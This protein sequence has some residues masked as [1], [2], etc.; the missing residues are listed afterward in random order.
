[1]KYLIILTTFFSFQILAADHL[2]LIGAGGEP[3]KESTIFDA[4][5]QN[6]AKYTAH[7][8]SVKVNVALN[9]GHQDTEK[10][11]K[12]S[13]SNAESKSNFFASDYQRLIQSYKRKLENNEIVAGDQ[14]LIYVESHGAAKQSRFKTHA[15]ATAEGTATDLNNLSG[16]T[17]VD[18]DQLEVIKNLAKRKGVKL[19]IVDTSCHSGNTL[20]LAD[21]NTCVIASTGPNHYGYTQFSRNFSS[22]MAKGKNLE[23]I[24]L[25]ARRNDATAGLPMIS[26]QTGQGITDL[27]YK[28]ITPYL[29]HFDSRHDK[30]TPYIEQ[31][32]CIE[33]YQS[34]I[35]T[36]NQIEALTIKK[37]K[38]KKLKRL[39]SDYEKSFEYIQT[40]MKKLGADRLKKQEHFKNDSHSISYTWKELL[41]TDFPR[42]TADL[43]TRQNQETSP[44]NQKLYQDLI[45]IYSSAETKKRDLL[46]THSD[47]LMVADQEKKIKSSIESNYFTTAAIATEERKLYSALYQKDDK[48]NPCKDFKL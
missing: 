15:I 14:L 8:P 20:A 35:A 38:L 2:M 36:F 42:M 1:M 33:N 19:A 25:E 12:D 6:L 22:A 41:S 21:E 44:Q 34:L 46:R 40:E 31:N 47:L 45:A 18:L 24:F 48:P 30:L 13:F 23:D 26:T 4:T 17:T 29:Y 9:G 27:L 43:R 7:N 16:S 5:I 11:L 10:I 28:K 39:L 37:L 3:K 32:E